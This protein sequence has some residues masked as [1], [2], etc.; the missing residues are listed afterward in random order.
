MALNTG[1]PDWESITL[2]TRPLF[3]K[4]LL[5][6][7]VQTYSLCKMVYSGIFN[8]LPNFNS[9]QKGNNTTARQK[10]RPFKFHILQAENE[11]LKSFII[12]RVEG[13]EV[14]NLFAFVCNA[15]SFA[16]A[17]IFFFF[18]LSTAFSDG[19]TKVIFLFFVQLLL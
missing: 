15:K 1:P 17:I 10:I 6:L 18:F 4:I 19:L 5:K 12:L 3:Y 8:L 14:K 13:N 9:R 2:T 11:Y 7:L 16:I